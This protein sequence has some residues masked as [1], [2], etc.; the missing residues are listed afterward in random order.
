VTELY[1]Y[2]ADLKAQL[3]EIPPD[4]IV[5]R[6]LY[7][8]PTARGVLFGFAPGQELSEHTSAKAAILHILEGS[9]TVTL[10]GDVIEAGPGS[11]AYMT[12][13][14]AH[15]VLAHDRVVMLLT[16]MKDPG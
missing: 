9:A 3:P 8:E 12:P 7:N 11:L 1:N 5:S 16:M 15:S 10:G 6:T 2:V 4:T 13:N 14:L